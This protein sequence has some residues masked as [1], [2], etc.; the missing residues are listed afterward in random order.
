M[1]FIRFPIS[2]PISDHAEYFT[3][4]APYA[5]NEDMTG[6]I[7]TIGHSTHPIDR[8]VEMLKAHDVT[9]LADV[10]SSP[11]SRFN[12]QFNKNNLK[13]A[14]IPFGIRY[15]FLG[16]ELG[17]RSTD[18]NCYVDGKVRF[19]LLAKTDSFQR[20]VRRLAEGCRKY[21]IALMCAEKDPIDCHRTILVSRNLKE[22]G[23]AVRH[24][25]ENGQLE[26]QDAIEKRLIS[27]FKMDNGD[28]FLSMEEIKDTAYRKQGELIAYA[29][30]NEPNKMSEYEKARA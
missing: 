20:G 12:P 8:F 9:A 4:V 6:T 15:V 24:I 14:L 25:L 19:D 7:F 16:A 27:M 21:R 2:A 18:S 10:R 17:A 13:E 23:F 1:G 5:L 22:A 28:L 30:Q 3:K 26:S 29:E 11:F